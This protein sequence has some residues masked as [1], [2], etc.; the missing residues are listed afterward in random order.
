MLV[1]ADLRLISSVA[2]IVYPP[3]LS[4]GVPTTRPY[5]RPC[6]TGVPS[7]IGSDC[8]SIV[9]VVVNGVAEP[10][11][12]WYAMPWPFRLRA[13]VFDDLDPPGHLGCRDG[14]KRAG[15]AVQRNQSCVGH[16]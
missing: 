3:E 6:G 4:G 7:T 8:G 13:A 1:L 5:P 16:G 12:N 11:L 9:Y 15:T 10:S 2:A 14:D